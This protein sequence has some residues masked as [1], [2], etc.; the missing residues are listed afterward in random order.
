MRKKALKNAVRRALRGGSYLNNSRYLRS[1][2]R[3]W[4]GPE[5]RYRDYGF[6]LIARKV[7]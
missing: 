2:D 1:A 5:Y 4:Y 3:Y 6:R 7:R